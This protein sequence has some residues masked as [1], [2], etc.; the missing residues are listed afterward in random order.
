LAVDAVDELRATYSDVPPLEDCDEGKV[1][2]ALAQP[3][4]SAGGRDA[5]RG[6]AAKLGALIYCV[7]KS[8]MCWTGVKRVTAALTLAMLG[9]SGCW[10]V[11]TADVLEDVITR[12][13][14]SDPADMEATMQWVQ[15]WAASTMECL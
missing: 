1:R 9:M 12:C 6:D 8:H 13:A 15:E 2:S 11:T 4:Q 14:S 7:A 3:F 5:Y 10:L